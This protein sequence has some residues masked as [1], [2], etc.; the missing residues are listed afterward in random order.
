M[1]MKRTITT[2]GITATILMGAA[3]AMATSDGVIEGYLPQFCVDPVTNQII[4]CEEEPTPDPWVWP[5]GDGEDGGDTGGTPPVD[6]LLP[7]PD[8]GDLPPPIE[9]PLPPPA[10]PPA[11]EEPAPADPPAEEEPAPAEEEAAPVDETET[12]EEEAAPVDETETVEEEAAP[13][14]E[15]EA[16]EEEAA[17]VDETETAEEDDT[18][19]GQTDDDATSDIDDDTTDETPTTDAVAADEVS[20][21]TGGMSAPVAVGV[22]AGAVTLLMGAVA[23]GF[24]VGR[25]R[26]F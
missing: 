10:D 11:E 3:P 22:G 20:E 9:P 15:T 7:T 2:I 13:V 18:A 6:E 25:R 17:P 14:D 21:D 19:V 16:V 4:V 26:P 5:F 24:A 8:L 12:A 23:A 1:R